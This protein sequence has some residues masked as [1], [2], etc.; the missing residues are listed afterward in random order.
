MDNAPTPTPALE[1]ATPP[2]FG[3][4]ERL[5]LDAGKKEHKETTATARRALQVGGHSKPCPSTR[6]S[7]SGAH[8]HI[9]MYRNP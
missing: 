5:M 7:S 2:L 9:G 8:E 1:P 4:D 6:H 3:Y